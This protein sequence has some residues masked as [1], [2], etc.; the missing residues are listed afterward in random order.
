[1]LQ[2]TFTRC[3]ERNRI[4]KKGSKIFVAIF[5]VSFFYSL[6]FLLKYCQTTHFESIIS[7]LIVSSIFTR[8]VTCCVGKYINPKQTT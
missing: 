6:G 3:R 5:I 2:C 7:S 8:T 1:M 4:I